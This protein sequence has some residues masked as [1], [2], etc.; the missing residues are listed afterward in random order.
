M[1]NHDDFTFRVSHAQAGSRP[2]Y[3]VASDYSVYDVCLNL[4]P[5]FPVSRHFVRFYPLFLLPPGSR[6]RRTAPSFPPAFPPFAPPI[7][8]SAQEVLP[9]GGAFNALQSFFSFLAVVALPVCCRIVQ[10]VPPFAYHFARGKRLSPLHLL[11]GDSP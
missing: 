1:P 4:F 3:V 11:R 9:L 6:R 10:S 5:T 7:A 8:M 2:S